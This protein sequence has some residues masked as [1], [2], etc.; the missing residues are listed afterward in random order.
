[1]TGVQTSSLMELV[2][3]GAEPRQL[4]LGSFQLAKVFASVEPLQML[5]PQP[6]DPLPPFVVCLAP[7]HRYS[8]P[9]AAIANYRK[10]GGLNNRNVFSIQEARSQNQGVDRATVPLKPVG[11]NPSLLLQLLALPATLGIP[12]LEDTSAPPLPSP[13][14]GLLLCICLSLFK[15]TN[16]PGLRESLESSI[17]SS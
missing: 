4:L 14:R 13:S 7:M 6:G 1:M 12:W 11:E 3:G 15:D 5:S 8:F 10:P 9:I 16:H 2:P 17:T